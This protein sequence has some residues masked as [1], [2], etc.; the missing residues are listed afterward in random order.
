MRRFVIFVVAALA[1]VACAQS[2]VEEHP[3]VVLSADKSE[4]QADGV[5]AAIFAVRV[6]GQP[7]TSGVTIYYIDDSAALSDM[8]FSTMAA[9]EYR[10]VAAYEGYFSNEVR[11]VAKAVEGSDGEGGSSGEETDPDKEYNVGDYYNVNGVEGIVFAIEKGYCYIFSLDE[12]DLQWSTINVDCT[13][14]HSSNGQWMTEDLFNPQYGAQNIEDYPAFKWCIEHGEGW[15]LPSAEELGW[16]WNTISGGTHNFQS[17]SVKAYNKLLVEKGGMPFT[18][19]YYMSSNETSKEMMEVVA[20]MSDSV[21]CL[22][23]YKTSEF[24]VRAAYRFPVE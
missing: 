22:E 12:A 10:F 16:M 3:N 9:G 14:N 19:T 6:N 18:E 21:V 7:V 20:F 17:D 1:F 8:S 2:G 23:P 5:D 4:I 13:Y 11:I 24:S 15:F